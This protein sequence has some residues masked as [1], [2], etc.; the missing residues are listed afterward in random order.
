MGDAH[1]DDPPGTDPAGASI[2]AP[3]A[4]IPRAAGD[5][6]TATTAA[7]LW[8]AARKMAGEL[9]AA[10]RARGG[11]PVEGVRPDPA[12]EPFV[13]RWLDRDD[14]GALRGVVTFSPVAGGHL[15]LRRVALLAGEFAGHENIMLITP[16]SEGRAAECM[17]YDTEGYI[18]LYTATPSADGRG[19]ELESEP[20]EGAPRYRQTWRFDDPD[21]LRVAFAFA[22][23]GGG[24]P[25]PHSGGALRREA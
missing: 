17:Y 24:E 3:F 1:A 22:A 12:W 5:R 8:A 23:A 9:D 18:V 19:F 16:A 7:V 4:S 21:T 11:A 14:A 2:R 10:M 25:E 20:V 15:L 13:G 6:I